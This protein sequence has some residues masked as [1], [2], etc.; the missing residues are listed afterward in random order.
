MVEASRTVVDLPTCHPVVAHINLSL[1]V[2][3]NLPGDT[4]TRASSTCGCYWSYIEIASP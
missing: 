3:S 2:T 1:V 4:R